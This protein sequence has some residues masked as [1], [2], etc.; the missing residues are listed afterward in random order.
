MV[1]I[2]VG[3]ERLR[4]AP[5]T[6]SAARAHQRP[7]KVGAVIRSRC[8]PAG[9]YVSVQVLDGVSDGANADADEAW[10]SAIETLFFQR[11]LGQTHIVRSCGLSKD[12]S[13][14]LI[15]LAVRSLEDAAVSAHLRG[16]LTGFFLRARDTGHVG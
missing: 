5:V 8:A 15:L 16:G 6:V 3:A 9:V 7:R 12:A 13:C 11:R 1:Q 2:G 10:A 14:Q 4:G